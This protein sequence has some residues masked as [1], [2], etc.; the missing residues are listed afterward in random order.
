[1]SY[2][3]NCSDK[4][5]AVSQDWISCRYT[6][7]KKEKVRYV[8][9]ACC[10]SSV[11]VDSLSPSEVSIEI[12]AMYAKLAC[13]VKSRMSSQPCSDCGFRMC[14]LPSEVFQTVRPSQEKA[15]I[16]RCEG[17]L[18]MCVIISISQGHSKH[19]ISLNHYNSLNHY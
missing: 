11:S 4:R 12:H 6:C 14:E 13:F 7:D 2:E 18:C 17:R 19:C 3:V 5:K 10:V 8:S 15:R 9:T 1:M 16:V